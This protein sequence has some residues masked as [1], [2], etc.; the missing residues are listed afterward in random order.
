MIFG[1]MGMWDAYFPEKD[2][3]WA[4]AHTIPRELHLNEQGK[5]TMTPVAELKLLR[6]NQIYNSRI[7]VDEQL[8]TG[9]P[10]NSTELFINISIDKLKADKAGFTFTCMQNVAAGW[11]Q[12][13]VYYDKKREKIVSTRIKDQREADWKGASEI[14]LHIYVDR[15][16]IEIFVNGGITFTSRFYVPWL[17]TLTLFTENGIAEV[18]VQAYSLKNI[19]KN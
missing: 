11:G 14:S 7:L 2:D 3:G 19:W 16:S 15:S 4:G 8:D 10:L 9:I 1:W 6:E 17:P 18:D 13:R 12:F 5:L